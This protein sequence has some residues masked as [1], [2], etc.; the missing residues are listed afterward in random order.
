VCVGGWCE[1]RQTRET[2]GENGRGGENKGDEQ[3]KGREEEGNRESR[4]SKRK[5]RKE[6]NAKSLHLQQDTIATR[7]T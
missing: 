5:E 6:E 3:W 4:G 1:G 7:P 2:E